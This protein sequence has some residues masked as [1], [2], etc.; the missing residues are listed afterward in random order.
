MND[1]RVKFRGYQVVM[2]QLLGGYRNTSYGGIIKFDDIKT[3]R[4]KK[5]QF[6]LF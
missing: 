3:I 4:S 6:K 5:I 1:Y 2:L